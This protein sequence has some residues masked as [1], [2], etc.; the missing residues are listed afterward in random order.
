M[1]GKLFG[2]ALALLSVATIGVVQLQTKAYVDTTPDCDQYAVIK[3]GTAGPAQLRTEYDT[4][5]TS[6]SN[7]STVRQGDIH[8]IFSALGISRAELNGTFKT[9]VVYQNGNVVV[10]GKVVATDARMA[11]RNLG[12]TAIAGANAG[13]MS[14]SKM[15][16]AQEAMVKFDANG[17]FLFAVM[18]PCGNPV[19]AKATQPKPVAKCENVKVEK[20]ERTKFRF[21]ASASAKYGAKV[22][23]YQFKVLRG[24]SVIKNV[25]QNSNTLTYNQPNA[26][27]YKVRVVAKTSLGDKTSEDCVKTFTVQEKPEAFC[28]NVTVQT[29]S[30]TKFSFTAKASTFRSQVTG[31]IFRVFKDGT[32]IDEKTV[33]TSNLSAT[34]NYSQATAGDYTVKAI[35]KTTL[36]N[37]T[38]ADCEKPFSV[39]PPEK[40]PGVK[41]EKTVNGVEL[42]QV[43][44]NENFTYEIA[45]TNTGDVDLTNVDVVDTPEAGVTLAPTQAVGTVANNTW[46]YTIPT[47]K[48]GETQNFTLNAMVPEYLAGKIKNTVCVDTTDVPGEPDDCDDAYVEVPKPHVKINKLVDGVDY[49]LVGVNVEFTYQIAVTN[50]GKVNLKNVKVSDQ[51]PAGVTFLAASAGTVTPASWNHTIP[52]LAIGETQN[53]TITAK[54]PNHKDNSIVNT[55]CVDA[56]EVPGSP[57]DC[58]DATVETKK[59]Y[60]CDPATGEIIKVD[61]SEAGNYEPVNSPACKDIVVCNLETSEIVTIKQSEYDQNSEM[62][63]TN[64]ADCEEENMVPVCNP[65]TGEIITVTESEKD[66]YLPVNSDECKDLTVCRVSDK[67][68]VV[69]K[70]SAY[71]QTV[72]TTDLT[73]CEETPVTPP[74]PPVKELPVTGAADVVVKLAGATSLAGAGAYYLLSRRRD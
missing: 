61:Q 47:L 44:L 27:D 12:G 26:G 2:F 31:Y 69:I 62:Y 40:H 51:A 37:K 36:G 29:I 11:A 45:V 35:V 34:V 6:S 33:T 22:T 18:T 32:K 60:V 43:A 9:G 64:L 59:V 13:I 72:Y 21:T 8:K 5:N 42:A 74:Q 20:L 67:A 73:K 58:D 48:V 39:T 28:K 46:S 52:A 15:G 30:R 3:C 56:T 70:K 10:G 7:G 14:V 24:S 17:R 66:N 53:F 57:D 71:D 41:V 49:K 1:K 55:A 4:Y 16:S 63:S 38:S 68:I 25:T 19:A 54:V 65:A 23:G 50:D